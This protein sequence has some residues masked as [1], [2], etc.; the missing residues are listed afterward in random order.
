MDLQFAIAQKFMASFIGTTP[1]PAI[2]RAIRERQLAGVTLFRESNVRDPGQI[3]ELTQRLQY[4]ARQADMPPLLI[5]ADQ[6]GGQLMAIDKDTTPFPGNMAL[7]AIGSAELAYQAG[8]VIGRELAAMGI[9]VNYAPVC[10]VNTNPQNP[11]IGVRSFGEDPHRVAELATAF[12]RGIQSTG[13]IATAKHFP[14]HGDTQEDSHFTLPIVSHDLERLNRV[15]FVPFRAA[16]AAGVRMIMTAH[17]SIPTITGLPDLPATLSPAILRGVLREQMGF[18][19][20]IITDALTMKAIRSAVTSASL[21][22]DAIAAARAGADLLLFGPEPFDREEVFQNLAQA[23]HRGLLEEADLR[24]SADRVLRLRNSVADLPT[25]DLSVVGCA[26]H[27]AVAEEIAR[28]SITLVR[29]R[30]GHLPLKLEG[31]TPIAAVMPRPVDLTPADTSSFVKPMLAEAL[32][33]Y[34]PRVDEFLISIDPNPAEIAALREALRSYPV[35]VLGTVNACQH[36][37]Q[38]ELVRTLAKQHD[39]LIWAALRL[40]YDLQAAPDAPTY[41]CTYSIL[42]ISLEALAALI[43]GH[44]SPQ[45]R[46]P[47]TIPDLYPLGHGLSDFHHQ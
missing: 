29:N 44:L 23:I 25:P 22:L 43:M 11:V 32:R 3:R 18:H 30:H 34:H 19:G 1:S 46:L 36:P 27:R 5:A 33:R 6:E 41:L 38:A 7:G 24:Y 35:V 17:L 37:G 8:E 13:V 40:P 12:I 26:A 31:E 39:R 9:N 20:V 21:S 10:D 16:I 4:A 28:R 2:M 42:P 15:E 14:G 45:G 47:V